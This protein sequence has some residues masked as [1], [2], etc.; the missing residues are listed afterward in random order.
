MLPYTN[1]TALLSAFQRGEIHARKIIFNTYFHPLCLFSERIT[2]NIL[3]SEDIVAEVFEKLMSAPHNFS[4]MAR[5]KSFLYQSVHNASIN[6]VIARKRY[7]AACNQVRYLAENE[8]YDHEIV[9]NEIMRAELIHE[10]YMAMDKLPDKC[11]QIFKMIFV[12]DLSTVEIA[13]KL[14][15]NVQTVRTQKARAIELIRNLLIKK[16]LQFPVVAYLT[17]LLDLPS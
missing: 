12:E 15:I 2:G 8:Q 17:L 9:Q 7:S 3:Q 1:D 4:A 11:G 16:N 6:Y 5:L 10:I 13:E 14:Q